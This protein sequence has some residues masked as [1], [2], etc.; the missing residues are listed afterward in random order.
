[1]QSN[2]SECPFGNIFVK[3]VAFLT[4]MQPHLQKTLNIDIYSKVL[5]L[6]IS[7]NALSKAMYPKAGI[8]VNYLPSTCKVILHT[9]CYLAPDTTNH[10][11]LWSYLLCE[12]LPDS[13]A[14]GVTF[15]VNFY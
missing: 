13:F 6:R 8:S 12:L 15:S 3:F 4:F 9:N 10:N 7:I 2:R 11:F 14:F 5:L 1:M